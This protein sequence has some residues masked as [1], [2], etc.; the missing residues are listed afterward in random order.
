[1]PI[2]G[3][4]GSEQFRLN[5]ETEQR[6]ESG[7]GDLVGACDDDRLARNVLVIEVDSGPQECVKRE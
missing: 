2:N 6:I 1:L 5:V 7:G 3:S 4:P